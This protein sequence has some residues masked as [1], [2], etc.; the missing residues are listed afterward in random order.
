MDRE[1]C[2]RCVSVRE[3]FRLPKIPLARASSRVL[4]SWRDGQVS[5]SRQPEQKGV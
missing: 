2:A 5:S 1:E 4:W 3:R